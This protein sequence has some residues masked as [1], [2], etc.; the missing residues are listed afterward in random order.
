MGAPKIGWRGC[1]FA[2]DRAAVPFLYEKKGR[3]MA[4]RE[5]ATAP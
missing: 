3:C 5:Q 4:Q 2:L 1:W